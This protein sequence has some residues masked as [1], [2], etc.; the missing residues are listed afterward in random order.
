MIESWLQCWK[1]PVTGGLH[2]QVHPC[3]AHKLLIA[4]L[5][6][7]STKEGALY[8]EGGV[9]DD[10]KSVREILYNMQRPG[11]APSVSL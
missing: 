10:L 7:G 1:N 2:F 5:P 9:V 8:P 11:I 4:P 6:E 3:G